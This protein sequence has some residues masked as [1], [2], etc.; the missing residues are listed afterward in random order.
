L[1]VR[2]YPRDARLA[3]G[4]EMIGTLL[5]AGEDSG[6]ALIRG[7]ASLIVGGLHDRARENARIGARRLITDAFCQAAVFWSLY[8]LAV[9]PPQVDGSLGWPT[10]TLVLLA[11]VPV[12]AILGMD[13]L[14]GLCGVLVAGYFLIHAS[15]TSSVAGQPVLIGHHNAIRFFVDRWSGPL[16]CYAVMFVKPRPRTHNLTRLLWLMPVGVLLLIPHA[17]AALLILIALPVLGIFYLPV[18]PRLAIA[19]ALLWTDTVVMATLDGERLGLV[20]IPVLSL[21][22]LIAVARQRS[23]ARQIHT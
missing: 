5:D 7:T 9:R 10:W 19:S 15:D 23:L 13:R 1:A 4:E 6:R 2:A 20:T 22:V 16:V 11:G 8:M 18:D 3:R 17:P 12:L 14:S 21:T